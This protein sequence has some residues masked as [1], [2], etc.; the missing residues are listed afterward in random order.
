[1]NRRLETF[2]SQAISA[3]SKDSGVVILPIGATEQHGPHLP[4]MTDTRQLSAVLAAAFDLLDVDTKAWSLP[5]LPYSKSNE[6]AAF[7][8][9]LSLS[10]TTLMSVLKDLAESVKRSGF[11]RLALLNGHGGN[12]GLL[13]TVARDIHQ[14]TGLICFVIQPSF[15]LQS[16]FELSA[17]E[18]RFGIHAGE[19]ETSLMLKLEPSLV[20]MA[21]AVKSYPD[22]PTDVLHLFGAASVAWLSDDWSASG[23]FGDAT[24]ANQEKGEQI[25]S[26]AAERLAKLIK[27]LSLFEVP[28]A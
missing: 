20:D 9:T 8:G 2:S 13:D 21:K 26:H 27:I 5:A 4:V 15:W 16:P 1:M 11:K 19:L 17:L 12:V 3:L 6:H 25:L 23:V 22:F 18:S 14:E 28:N 7:S 10:A 24:L